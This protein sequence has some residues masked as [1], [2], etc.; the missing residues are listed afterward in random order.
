MGGS[1]VRFPAWLELFGHVVVRISY[2][3]AALESC[4]DGCRTDIVSR[5]GS[6]PIDEPD[7]ASRIERRADVAPIVA[8]DA[9]ADEDGVFVAGQF[10]H[11]Q[12]ADA[13]AEISEQRRIVDT[14][15]RGA[16]VRLYAQMCESM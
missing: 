10:S 7:D 6:S 8:V 13:F 4:S 16:P 15:R 2:R 12:L 1:L 11:P 3:R 5:C 14:Q 9:A